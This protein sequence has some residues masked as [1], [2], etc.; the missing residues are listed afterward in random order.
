MVSGAWVRVTDLRFRFEAGERGGGALACDSGAAV[1]AVVDTAGCKL[2]GSAVGGGW[3]L[4]ERGGAAAGEGFSV[5]LAEGE[6]DMAAE[7]AV[8]K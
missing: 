7:G 2:G 1:A 3:E 4:G 5:R 8:M 6:E